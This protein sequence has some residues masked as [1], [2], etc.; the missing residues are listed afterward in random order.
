[1]YRKTHR[2]KELERK[3]CPCGRYLADGPCAQCRPVLARLWAWREAWRRWQMRRRI[4]RR[5]AELYA[6]NGNCTPAKSPLDTR[7]EGA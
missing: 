5:V 7:R 3:R 6:W 2:V 1:M 4:A